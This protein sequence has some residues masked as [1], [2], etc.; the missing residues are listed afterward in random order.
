MLD[1]LEK[2]EKRYQDIEQ[3]L[4][5]PEISSDQSQCQK[6]GKELSGLTPT[7]LALRAYKETLK[8]INDLKKLLKEKHDKEFEEL[9]KSELEQL[10]ERQREL[11]V[12][13]K[14]LANP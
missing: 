5:D 12:Q 1:K 11:E 8:Q 2:V 13:L 14:D 9:F 7:V 6:L 10:Q 4:A 3:L